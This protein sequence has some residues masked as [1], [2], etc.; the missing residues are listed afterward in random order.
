MFFL[1]LNSLL[2]KPN[3]FFSHHG[4]VDQVQMEGVVDVLVG[5]QVGIVI[6]LE[7][8]RNLLT[9]SNKNQAVQDNCF[10]IW[11]IKQVFGEDYKGV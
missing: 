2:L 5:D 6:I 7:V 8:L 9:I 4:E 10:E 11:M 3:I 1:P